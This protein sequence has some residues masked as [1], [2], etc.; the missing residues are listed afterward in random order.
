[1][2][3]TTYAGRPHLGRRAKLLVGTCL[4]PAF[5]ALSTP[6]SQASPSGGTVATGQ[7][8]IAVTG[9]TVTV[10]Q[11]SNRAVINWQSF[12]VGAGETARF[13]LPSC[14]F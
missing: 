8:T 6:M 2:G 3:R 12:S 14:L 4:V 11:A 7:A 5:M 1:M 9:H 10:N 13:N